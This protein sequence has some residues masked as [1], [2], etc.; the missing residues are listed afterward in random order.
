MYEG[1]NYTLC[2]EEDD[3]YKPIPEQDCLQNT[4]DSYQEAV[5]ARDE[6]VESDGII[7]VKSVV[8]VI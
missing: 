4:F 5:N 7:I 1:T 6:L 3:Q 2:F 8:K